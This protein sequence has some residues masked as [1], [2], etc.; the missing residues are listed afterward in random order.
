MRA[1]TLLFALALLVGG[2]LVSADA[3]VAIRRGWSMVFAAD[4]T[5]SAPSISFGAEP[6][7]GFRR[8][9][10]GTVDLNLNSATA[11]LRFASV[12]NG[13]QLQLGTGN[14]AFAAGFPETNSPDLLVT[15]IGAGII[16][17]GDADST[18]GAIELGATLFAALGTP[19]NGTQR[20]CSDCTFANPCAGSGTGAIA[21]RLAG[22]WRCD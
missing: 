20:Y 17:F 12:A 18:D 11:G 7:T 21:K 6:T 22:A 14:I 2:L 10:T 9:T 4:G 5:A 1:R 19:S 15:R 13:G 8:R 3:Q 16:K